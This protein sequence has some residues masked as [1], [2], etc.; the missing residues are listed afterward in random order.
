MVEKIFITGSVGA[1]KT[2]LARRL[3]AMLGIPFHEGDCI[4]WEQTGHGRVKRS[5]QRQAERI[6]EIDEAGGWIIEGTPRKSQTCLFARAQRVV[7]LDPPLRVRLA[8]VISRFVKQKLGLEKSHYKPTLRMLRL[9]FTWTFGFERGRNE[10]EAIACAH[11]DKLMVIRDAR[12]SDAQLRRIA[13]LPEIE[14]R[15]RTP[16]APKRQEPYNL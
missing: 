3:S 6:R 15:E 8:R 11:R 2:T 16:H 12:V 1:G 7:W 9:M 5:D 13:G 4:A 14:G 10:F